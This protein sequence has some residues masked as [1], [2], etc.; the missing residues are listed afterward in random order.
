MTQQL[1]NNNKLVEKPL[2]FLCLGENASYMLDILS[3]LDFFMAW[4]LLTNAGL[5]GLGI[6]LLKRIQEELTDLQAEKCYPWFYEVAAMAETNSVE[7]TV[8]EER[9][10]HRL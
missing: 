4:H 10:H 3:F 8:S 2:V 5:K 7:D 6:L 9:I 1:N